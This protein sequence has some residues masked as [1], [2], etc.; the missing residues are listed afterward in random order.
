[1]RPESFEQAC[2]VLGIPTTLPEFPHLAEKEQNSLIADYKL[3]VIIK[4]LNGDNVAD[5]T[6]GN[7]PKQ[8]PFFRMNPFSLYDVFAYCVISCVPSRLCPLDEEDAEYVTEKFSDLYK[9]YMT[10]E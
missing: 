5:W 8:Q 2:D 10:G 7:Q 4:V 3:T 9:A 1:M 6:N